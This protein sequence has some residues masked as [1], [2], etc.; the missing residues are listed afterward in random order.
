MTSYEWMILDQCHYD[1]ITK[2]FD[3]QTSLIGVKVFK[4]NNQ[5]TSYII[6]QTTRSPGMI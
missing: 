4:L 1:N 6:I 5:S 3:G 2:L